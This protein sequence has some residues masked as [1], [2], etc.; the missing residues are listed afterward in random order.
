MDDI[1]L[2]K[3]GTDPTGTDPNEKCTVS[4]TDTTLRWVRVTYGVGR[5]KTTSEEQSFDTVA[6][7]VRAAEAMIAELTRAR[8]EPVTNAAPPAH[9]LPS[10]AKIG[11]VRPSWFEALPKPLLP[12]RA[13]LL[14]TAKSKGLAHRF[15]EIEA[16]MKPGMD[17]ALKKAKPADPKGVVSRLGGEPDL[18][19][20]TAW[21]EWNGAALTFVAQIVITPEVKALDLEGL[22]PAEGVLSFFAQ[23]DLEATEYGERCVVLHFPSSKGLVRVGPPMPGRVLKS[24]GLFTPKARLTV[25]PSEA[26]GIEALGLTRDEQHAYHDELFLGPIP[27]GRHH[28]L[29]GWPDATTLHDRKGR[30][31]LAQFDSDHR[32][33]FQMGDD[34][35]LRFYV[36]GDAVDASSLKTAVC[37][38]CEE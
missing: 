3:K 15:D 9:E 6:E 35:T 8:F 21:P 1:V 25:A 22:L 26:P 5:N 2:R 38:L 19:S 37:T 10:Q 33:D 11:V 7:A 34:D 30:R 32:L 16:R 36:D 20:A 17:L 31:F 14:K 29:L 28:M 18:A 13:K 4:V 24:A 12:Q 27:E 23:L